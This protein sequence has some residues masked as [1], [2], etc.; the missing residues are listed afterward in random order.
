MPVI[1]HLSLVP[2]C[3]ALAGCSC[4]KGSGDDSVA[5][6]DD[7]SPSADDSS[8][9]SGG[10]DSRVDDSGLDDSGQTG[11]ECGDESVPGFATTMDPTCENSIATSTLVLE[12]EWS[13][14]VWKELPGANYIMAS[15]IVVSLTDDNGDG[16]IDE[17]DIPDIVVNAFDKH[18][19]D[20]LTG[21][22]LRAVS[23]DG[24]GELWSVSPS[25]VGIYSA[26]AAADIDG[27]GMVEV[28]IARTNNTFLTYEHDGTL[29]WASES[30]P[31]NH[32][33]ANGDA[34]HIADL[35]HNGD[36]EIIV[37]N[38]IFD[39]EGRFLA[40][41][42]H[43]YAQS[44]YDGS[45]PTTADIDGDG[46]EDLVGGDAVYRL[47]GTDLWYNGLEVGYPA[48]AD[49]DLDGEPDIVV[50]G[51]TN[52]RIDDH[53]GNVLV[54]TV[55]IP[56]TVG[57]SW[58]ESWGG[59]PVVADFDGDGAPE[60]GVASWD[61]FTVFD[62]DLSI[63]W[64]VT[65]QDLSSGMTSATA[66]DFDGDGSAEVVYGDEQWIWVLSGVDGSV[67]SQSAHSSKTWL[68]HPIVV[69]V[70]GDDQAEIV[71]VS[72]PG[73]QVYGSGDDSWPAGRRIWNEHAYHI[74]NVNDDGTIP[75]TE[76]PSWE[77]YNSFR[78]GDLT[79]GDALAAPD[80]SVTSTSV[81]EVECAEGKI[82]VWVQVANEGAVDLRVPVRF[83]VY[84]VEGATRTVIAGAAGPATVPVGMVADASEIRITDFDASAAE[85]VVVRVDSDEA[86]CDETNN[87]VEIPGPF[88]VGK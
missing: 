7:S 58:G 86:E 39:N 71:A 5:H 19:L 8:D 15:P 65:T 11:P 53:E 28:I 84:A 17:H 59:P 32:W 4:S 42:T 55:E 33:A 3:A 77:F 51:E 70:D 63:L 50:A 80:L 57:E 79:A 62:S 16:A 10:D 64:S 46:F 2:S 47:D 37:G 6:S 12:L 22:M 29:K 43:G 36:P 75:E 21:G 9:D 1:V 40:A 66:F 67:R 72:T 20:G 87:E 60:V 41:G 48:V 52:V 18:T 35:D 82:V 44:T 54:P 14:E 49:F 56:S 23:G 78:S 25:G 34:P 76:A 83:T 69:D 85:S 38:T 88:C 45:M 31:G 81:C 68:E 24:S 26:P 30:A 73:I 74:T 27:D 13:M 61:N